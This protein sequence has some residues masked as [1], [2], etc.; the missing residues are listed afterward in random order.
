MGKLLKRM[1]I[2]VG[3]VVDLISHNFVLTLNLYIHTQVY[4]ILY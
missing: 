3:R 2:Q 1:Y 4:L